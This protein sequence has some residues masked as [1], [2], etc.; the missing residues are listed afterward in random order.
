MLGTDLDKNINTIEVSDCNV[1]PVEQDSGN[2]AKASMDDSVKQD[3]YNNQTIEDKGKIDSNN[4]K[5][6]KDYNKKTIIENKQVDNN[7]NVIGQ[8]QDGTNLAPSTDN[9]SVTMD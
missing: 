5:G 1:V 8:Q 9:I 6:T 4:D 2:N 7:N 3:D